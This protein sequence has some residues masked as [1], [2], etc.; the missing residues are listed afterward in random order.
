MKRFSHLLLGGL[1]LLCCSKSV[2]QPYQVRGNASYLG[3]DCFELTPNQNSQAGAVWY[4]DQVNLNEPF[5]IYVDIFLGCRDAGA[6]GLAFVLQPNNTNIGGGGGGMGYSNIPNSLAIEFDTWNNDGSGGSH[7]PDLGDPLYDH[8]AIQT[9]GDL[10]HHHPTHNLAGPIG[11]L[12]NQPNLEDCRWHDLHITWN[13][14]T[15]RIRVYVDCQLRFNT[16]V[17]NIIQTVFNG[18]NTVYW[19]FAAGTGA[20]R[21]RHAFCLDYISF[22]DQMSNRSI[23]QGSSVQLDA[24]SGVGYSWSPT[25]GLSNP[26]IRNPLASPTSTTTY[27][28]TVTDECGL[29]SRTDDVTVY[30]YQP[31]T[32]NLGPDLHVCTDEVVTLT[33]AHTHATYFNWSTGETGASIQVDQ[34]GIITVTAG[35]PGCGSVSDEVEISWEPHLSFALPP[36]QTICEG[37]SLLL[38]ASDPVGASYLWS[39]GDT[40][41]T[42]WA[43]AEGW[44]WA[45]VSNP[46]CPSRRDSFYLRLE[47]P[48]QFSVGPDTTICEGETLL[49]SALHPQAA[50]YVWNSGDSTAQ[51]MV[52][53]PGRYIASVYNA[54]CPVVHDTMELFNERPMSLDLGAD[55][56]LCQGQVLILDAFS[57]TAIA[58]LWNTG[59]SLPLLNVSQSGVYSVRLEAEYC[60]SVSDEIVVQYESPVTIELGPDTVLCPGESL[61]LDITHPWA[62][63]YQWSTGETSPSL[64]PTQTGLYIATAGNLACPEAT[65]SIQITFSSPQAAFDYL[66]DPQSEEVV[67]D[68]VIQFRSLSQEAASQQ[69]TMPLLDWESEELAPDITFRQPGEY[70]VQLLV[71][72]SFDHCQ[73][74]L[75]KTLLIERP[76]VPI[77]TAF[78]PNGDG[79]NDQMTIR[80]FGI[81][82]IQ[83]TIFNRWGKVVF[84]S[85]N[86]TNPWDGYSNQG[87]PVPE[88]V[89]TAVVEG[90]YRSGRS[91]RF[92]GSVTLFR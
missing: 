44:Y 18:D 70:A 50:S 7:N 38:D 22:T 37:D 71:T 39:T 64:Q 80:G 69:W 59:D 26:N 53:L 24:G 20:E 8:L 33:A 72:D 89:Y 13:P 56:L 43:K 55:S 68:E 74:S 15:Q 61:L 19:G 29:V 31:P 27:T 41:A 91:F 75:T 45:E 86:L 92:E 49:L 46:F 78:S 85:S 77:P 17:G 23:C 3:N 57:P 12:S 65:D 36:D 52:S 30:V 48:I 73:D 16:F 81:D 21:N 14:Q 11:I 34:P 90:F 76:A 35:N 54:Y 4:N 87:L 60:P 67:I 79:I 42:L 88:G 40:S 47:P 2:A 58:Y 9:H 28:V 62:R 63:Y 6:D 82:Q 10:N 83:I 32:V 84:R 51:I 25:M 66:P 5:D 1:A